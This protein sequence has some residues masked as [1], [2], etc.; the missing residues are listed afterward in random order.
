[1]KWERKDQAGQSWTDE[2]PATNHNLLGSF[3][4]SNGWKC[5][6]E[7]D[8]CTQMW[9]HQ[10]PWNGLEE[11]C[12]EESITGKSFTV[13]SRWRVWVSAW[14]SSFS[15]A[16][17][18]LISLSGKYG[19]KKKEKKVSRIF[20]PLAYQYINRSLSQNVQKRK[21]IFY[22]KGQKMIIRNTAHFCNV[23]PATKIC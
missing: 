8:P 12:L 2:D 21:A 23:G 19:G 17:L 7:K 18:P 20:E 16:F 4:L 11:S 13:A 9:D 5:P 15:K 10:S 22:L 1:M 3:K 14:K 6:Y